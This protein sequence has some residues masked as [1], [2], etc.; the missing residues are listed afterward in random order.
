MVLQRAENSAEAK[1]RLLAARQPAKDD[2]AGIDPQLAQRCLDVVLV[3]VARRQ[4]RHDR[5]EPGLVRQR[6]HPIGHHIYPLVLF[7]HRT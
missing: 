1:M 6:R 7:W 4:L 5:A 2:H 3:E